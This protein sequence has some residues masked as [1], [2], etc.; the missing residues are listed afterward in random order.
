M[1]NYNVLPE[2][3][4]FP[5]EI[6]IPEDIQEEIVDYVWEAIVCGEFDLDNLVEM[7]LDSVEEEYELSEENAELIVESLLECRRKQTAEL[8]ASGKLDTIRLNAA[9]E[10]LEEKNVLAL[11]NFTCCGTCGAAEAYE[12]MHEEDNWIAY[13]YFHEQ[14][15]ERLIEDNE[16]YLGYGVRWDK[17]CSEEEFNRMSEKE[18]DDTYE[19]ECIKLAEEILKPVF[20]KHDIEFTWDNNLHTR[21]HI[22]NVDYFADIEEYEQD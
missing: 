10:E 6:D 20:A 17:I 8:K 13:I 9:F 18:R 15:T 4:V 14:D 19:A 1:S 16:T 2:N 12:M 7:A 3:Y 5:T 21:M 11:Q 22:A